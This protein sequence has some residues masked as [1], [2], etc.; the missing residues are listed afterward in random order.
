[1]NCCDAISVGKIKN[2]VACQVHPVLV[3][4][5]KCTVRFSLKFFIG[6]YCKNSHVRYL[7]CTK[8]FVANAWSGFIHRLAPQVGGSAV[9]LV[10]L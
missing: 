10:H 6:N 9:G 1:M 5:V 3:K 4:R 2:I 7:T 8:P